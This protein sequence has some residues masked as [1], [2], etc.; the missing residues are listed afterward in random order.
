MWHH[1]WSTRASTQ[2]AARHARCNILLG[3]A[4]AVRIKTYGGPKNHVSPHVYTPCLIVC[5]CFFCYLYLASSRLL[6]FR[7][8]FSWGP[9]GDPSARHTIRQIVAPNSNLVLGTR[10]APRA[11]ACFVFILLLFPSFL[12][13]FSVRVFF[14]SS[15]HIIPWIPSKC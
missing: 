14:V 3:W 15:V 5:V 7:L 8:V 1:R 12:F 11:H 4:Y 10:P 6:A 9:Y 2:G 13:L